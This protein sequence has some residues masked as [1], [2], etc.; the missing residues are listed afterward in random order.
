MTTDEVLLPPTCPRCGRRMDILME[1]PSASRTFFACEECPPPWRV[2][3]EA[4]FCDACV[5]LLSVGS[6]HA[7]GRPLCADCLRS[8][9]CPRRIRPK[10]GRRPRR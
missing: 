3:T 5:F 10:V 7:C 1:K 4:R 9:I 8:H 2:D 6:C